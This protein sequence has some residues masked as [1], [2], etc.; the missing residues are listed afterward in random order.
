MYTCISVYRNNILAHIH[1]KRLFSYKYIF[2]SSLTY[3]TY[4]TLPSLSAGLARSIL[5]ILFLS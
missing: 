2:G 1:K 4:L 3:L 5:N